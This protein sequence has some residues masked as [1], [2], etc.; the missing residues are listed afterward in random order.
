MK[1]CLSHIVQ[2]GIPSYHQMGPTWYDWDTPIG[3]EDDH[4]KGKGEKVG[5]SANSGPPLPAARQQGLDLPEW[6]I[7]LMLLTHYLLRLLSS[8]ITDGGAQSSNTAGRLS[9]L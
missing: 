8:S 2:Q 6:T 7:D 5:G 3:K 9:C 1:L 4:W